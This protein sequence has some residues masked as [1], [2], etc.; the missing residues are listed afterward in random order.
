MELNSNRL[1][2]LRDLIQSV[3][4]NW[5][6][7]GQGQCCITF[8]GTGKLRERKAI[9]IA[10]SQSKCELNNFLTCI[11]ILKRYK[12]LKIFQFWRETLAFKV[13]QPVATLD[14][15]F[16][17]DMAFNTFYAFKCASVVKCWIDDRK[18]KITRDSNFCPPFLARNEQ[19]TII[20]TGSN[21]K[22]KMMKL[23]IVHDYLI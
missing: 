10:I 21:P 1:K 15:N 4:E 16:S 13:V 6:S 8:W 19:K 22:S 20:L 3:V 7:P 9:E 11:L 18:T 2:T 5:F 17:L 23:F 14:V 12:F